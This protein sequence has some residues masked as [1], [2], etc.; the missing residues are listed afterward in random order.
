MGFEN[1]LLFNGYVNYSLQFISEIQRNIKHITS[2]SV[3]V[4]SHNFN[5]VGDCNVCKRFTSAK[6]MFAYAC[7]TVTDGYAFKT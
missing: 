6:R 1:I 4:K 2:I 7:D 3:K 5:T